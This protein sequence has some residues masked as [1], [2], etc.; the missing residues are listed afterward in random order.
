MKL[1]DPSLLREAC[2]VNGEW[3]TAAS[4]I[5]VTNPFDGSVVGRVPKFG[6]AE[7]EKAIKAAAAAWPSWRG[8]TP[9]A[10][11]A[12]LRAWHDLICKHVDD[13]AVIMTLEQGKPLAEAKAEIL[14]GAGYVEWFAEECRRVYGDVIP[15]PWAGARQPVTVYQSIGVSAAITP[16]NFPSAMITRKASPALAAGC[17]VIIKPASATPFSA[18]AMA[19][20][21]E[22]AGFPAGVFNIVTGGAGDIGGALTASPDVRALSF[23]GSTEVGK[24]LMA[25]C[26]ATMKKLGLE[27]GGNAPFV[28]FDDADLNHL[29]AS[30]PAS[31]FRNAGQ[32]CISPNRMLVQRGVY[33]EFLRRLTNAA[34]GMRLGSG[35]DAA[36][37]MGPMI[38]EDAV[39]HM[40]ELVADATARGARLLH[41]GKRPAGLPG[42]FFEP[43][44]LAD[45]T[46]GMRVF[47]EE[48]FGPIAGVM[49]F[50]DE[51]EAVRL[52]NDTPHGLAS[53]LFSRD[54]G[55]VWR[56]ANAIEAGMVA[57]NEVALASGEVPF[58]GIKESGLGREG[59]KPGIE[60][61][62]EMKLIMLGGL[63]R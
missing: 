58:G 8:R 12:V 31:K 63:D 57:V 29:E 55:R 59:G 40:E 51:A 24:D 23:T 13:L 22:R 56:M 3:L 14:M 10:R 7:T 54:I 36:T 50:A 5:E 46:P 30:F 53:Y 4:A 48:I 16:W 47:R 61:Y 2:Y 45:V 6:R 19:V 62:L 39:R 1:N 11:A 60:E 41:G 43:T 26:S 34:A 27:L 15:S 21:A 28:V 37:T 33:D 9:K 25:A 52:A 42:C 38:N 49:P 44:V 32:V 18:L 17:P 35:L 20:L